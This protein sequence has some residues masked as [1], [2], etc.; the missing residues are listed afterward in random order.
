MAARQWQTAFW[1]LCQTKHCMVPSASRYNDRNWRRMWA[2]WGQSKTKCLSPPMPWS[3]TK[4][5]GG[6][7][8]GWLVLQA[9]P[10][11]PAKHETPCEIA[12]AAAVWKWALESQS[13]AQFSTDWG[14]ETKLS[15]CRAWLKNDSDQDLCVLLSQCWLNGLV[16]FLSVSQG[17][18]DMRSWVG[19]QGHTQ[20]ISVHAF[21]FTTD[22]YLYPLS[23]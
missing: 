1:S 22:S 10:V 14:A 23:L 8:R 19:M 3:R 4:C 11:Q 12:S 16:R 20:C 9:Y 7:A 13:M 17:P 18:D 21:E 2:K 6:D 15:M 5:S